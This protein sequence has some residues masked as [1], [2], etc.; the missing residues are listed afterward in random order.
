MNTNIK[1]FNPIFVE[2]TTL[3]DVWFRL[4]WHLFDKGRRYQITEG[5]YA[6][7]ERLAFDDVSGFIH[8]PHTRPLAPIITDPSIPPPTTDDE[9]EHYFT[10]YLMDSN[11]EANEDYRYSTFIVGGEYELPYGSMLCNISNSAKNYWHIVAPTSVQVP[12]QIQWVIDH[13][14]KK[15]FGNEHCYITIGYPESLQAYDI[16]YTNEN[17]R[18]TSPCLRGLG[19]RVVDGYM[20]TKVIYRSW[21]LVSG[22][23]TNMGGFALLN[24]YVAYELG[25][26]PGPLSFS[27][28][29]LHAYDH[30][31]DYLKLRIG[32]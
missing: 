10:N 6:G 21:D 32:K 3:D 1:H 22:F 25:I 4:L 9:I 28:S 7:R 2:A 17:E 29:S 16:P 14:K 24:E 20:L 30:A 11:L 27:C 13:F 12:N 26:K 5:S 19:F 31:Y 15:G 8:H 18:K 23:P